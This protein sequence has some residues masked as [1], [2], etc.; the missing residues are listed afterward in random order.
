MTSFSNP[1]NIPAEDPADSAPPFIGRTELLREISGFLMEPSDQTLF[2]CGMPG[3]G[4]TAVLKRIAASPQGNFLPVYFAPRHGENSKP[5]HLL[6][7]LA[8][9]VTET[10][11]ISGIS[12][13]DSLPSRVFLTLFVPG[14]LTRMPKDSS[15]LLLIDTFS[16]TDRLRFRQTEESFY[17][18]LAEIPLQS[19]GRIRLIP[20]TGRHS[21]EQKMTALFPNAKRTEIPLFS[22]EESAQLIRL[23]EENGSLKW[24]DTQVAAVRNFT[25]GHPDLIR[26][27]CSEIWKELCKN[28]QNPA[29][30][31]SFR[32]MGQGFTRA[33]E[34][35]EDLFADI[36]QS[37][38]TEERILVS[39]L[40]ETGTRFADT[41]PLKKRLNGFACFRTDDGLKEI[42]EKLCAWGLLE[43]ENSR[44]RIRINMLCR[45]VMARKPFDRMQEE[46]SRRAEELYSLACEQCREGETEEAL[47]NLRA[48]AEI[49]PENLKIA[50]L[51]LKVLIRLEK[52]ADAIAF[53]ESVPESLSVRV[54]PLH[55]QA[56]LLQA[57]KTQENARQIT[58]YQ[59]VLDLDPGNPQARSRVRKSAE[60]EG[61]RLLE[62]NSLSEAL[63]F[64][65]LAGAEIKA[66]NVEESIAQIRMAAVISQRKRRE[67]LRRRLLVWGVVPLC[68]LCVTAFALYAGYRHITHD[69]PRIS[70]LADYR[71]PEVTSVY[72]ANLR[73]I[74]EF[75]RERRIVV[76]LSRMSQTLIQAFI[77][78]EDSRFFSHPGLDFIGIARA[79]FKNIEAG[80][81]VQGGSTITQQVIKSFLLGSERSYE[82]KCREAVLA[83]R[84]N[85]SFTKEEILFLYLNQIYLGYGAYGVEAAAENY[86]GKNAK[87]LNLAECAMLAGLA[88][89]PGKDTPAGYPERAKIRQKY[90]LRR[91][92]QEGYIT[93]AQAE[94]AANF[95][96]RIRPRQNWF[97]D[98]VPYF[99]EYVRQ[100]I[101]NRYGR[102]ELYAGG[103]KIYTTVDI[104]VQEMAKQELEKGLMDLENRHRYPK[105]A[106]L[107]GA[108][109]C[110]ELGTGYVRAM[111]GGRDF[112]ASQFNRAVQARRQPGSSFK[113]IIYAAAIDKGF[114]PL[115]IVYDSPVSYPGAHGRLWTPSNYDGR[116]YGP[117]RLRRALAKSRNV[118]AVRTLN[119]IG[120]D[121]AITYA[122]NLGITSHLDK[123]LPLA[124]G[125]SGISLL[126]MVQ[127][128][129]VFANQG[130]LIRPVFITKTEDRFGNEITETSVPAQVIEP[131]T[132]FIMTSLLRSVVENGT[133][134]RAKQLKRPVAGKTG[135]TNDFRDAWFIGYTPEYITGTW[136]GFDI[137]RSLG[138]GETGSQAALP[139]WLGFMQKLL[140]G[141]PV[142]E[143]PES[144]E[145]VVVTQIDASTGMLAH[146]DSANIIRECFKQGTE[147]Q[148]RAP[149]PQPQPVY[150][151]YRVVTKPEE[152]FKAD[153]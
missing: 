97:A 36:W 139:I 45:W 100:Y 113:P 10:L 11:H 16:G 147:P 67:K 76:P 54:R 31:V 70:T 125:A 34:K 96:L 12:I 77:S 49:R 69:L 28:R 20:A 29:P 55:V 40:A 41:E 152:F 146:S 9:T 149:R 13:G 85:K 140:D 57:E 82:R 52:T 66:G 19:S 129:S 138:K 108:M 145:G 78:A 79:F 25:A 144:A 153:M 88:K 105:D 94:E 90:V 72:A 43:A 3:I 21:D 87:D 75:Y 93:Q 150:P 111:V 131:A 99:T 46:F 107:Q 151:E 33:V 23:S 123:G 128:Y 27:L 62:S 71:P 106:S 127:A 103:L 116:Y 42:A 83:Y 121:Y 68:F 5:E 73:K 30:C 135:T 80:T 47:R 24:P 65:Q 4:K 84:I 7:D 26:C 22:P 89:A 44:Y 120:T 35:A 56:L 117:M 95:P 130:Q 98:G 126:E 91:M 86:F 118:P 102:E 51:V 50:S 1:Y 64:Y 148:Y 109:L 115:S 143:F 137:E 141:T 92:V 124:L 8:K 18:C 61:D 58:L 63:A 112:D 6:A 48:G 132:A 37:L 136:V 110:V 59:K 114:T 17:A 104:T 39:A 60:A 119:R 142:Q 74:G 53:A 2:L 122:R 134:V 14:L 38:G 32:D 133:G 101:E 15:L 81:V